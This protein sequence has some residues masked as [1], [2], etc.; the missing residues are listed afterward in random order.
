VKKKV[1]VLGREMAWVEA[2]EGRTIV[3][4]HGN[5]SSSC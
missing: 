1:R 5:P 2:G 3:F 4:L